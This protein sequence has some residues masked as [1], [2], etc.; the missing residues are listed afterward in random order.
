MISNSTAT[1][2]CCH[3]VN[4]NL[5]NNKASRVLKILSVT[6][7][8]ISGLALAA[9][10][11]IAF[12]LGYGPLGL[13]TLT[14]GTLG[15][16]A[17]VATSIDHW[18]KNRNSPLQNAITNNLGKSTPAD[19]STPAEQQTKT[20]SVQKGLPGAKRVYKTLPNPQEYEKM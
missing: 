8:I 19:K 14:I 7:M 6:A 16:L 15:T 4:N 11:A 17:T 5:E 20:Q 2:K 10:G 3:N 9:I 13:F 18:N 12:S 1:P